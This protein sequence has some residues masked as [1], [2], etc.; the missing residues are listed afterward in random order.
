MLCFVFFLLALQYYKLAENTHAIKKWNKL[1]YA[2][3]MKYLYIFTTPVLKNF[4][5]ATIRLKLFTNQN[6]FEKNKCIGRHV[7]NVVFA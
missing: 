1:P 5:K 4:M 6:E 2:L 3:D 7:T